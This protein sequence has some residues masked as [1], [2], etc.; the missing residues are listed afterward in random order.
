[1][2]KNKKQRTD[3][4]ERIDLERCTNFQVSSATDC[5]GLIPAAPC[6]E[7][8]IESYKEMYHFEAGTNRTKRPPNA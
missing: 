1:M 8:E 6:T 4:G 3:Y 5:T 2:E 7:E